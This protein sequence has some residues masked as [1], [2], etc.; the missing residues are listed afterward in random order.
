C[1]ELKSGYLF[2]VQSDDGFLSAV[3]ISYYSLEG[4]V[5]PL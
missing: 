2:I 1:G 4:V 5:M 3:M